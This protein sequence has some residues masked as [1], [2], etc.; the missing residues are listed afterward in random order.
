M[1]ARV[2]ENVVISDNHGRLHKGGTARRRP[3]AQGSAVTGKV[4]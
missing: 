3:G 4:G 1:Q 2:P